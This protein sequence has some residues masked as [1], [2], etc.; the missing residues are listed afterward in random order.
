MGAVA[1]GL[2]DVATNNTQGLVF[3]ARTPQGREM[4]RRCR[5]LRTKKKRGSDLRSRGS[6][7]KCGR[8]A[9]TIANA[10][11]GDDRHVDR[12]DD[13]RHLRQCP[14]L[15]GRGK[16]GVRSEK[17]RPMSAGLAALGDDRIDTPGFQP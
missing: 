16:V 15:P 1:N 2:V 13:L 6:E 3:A 11:G 12:I 9:A 8:Y 5:G 14:D 7:R 10:S 17:S 4:Q